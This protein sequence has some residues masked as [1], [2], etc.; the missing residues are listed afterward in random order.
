MEDSSGVDNPKASTS[1]GRRVFG[2]AAKT[3]APESRN[4]V[5]SDTFYA[6]SDSEDDMEAKENTADVGNNK[7]NDSQ[8]DVHLDSVL[9][10][11]NTEIVQ[12][13]VF[14]VIGLLW[15]LTK[16]KRQLWAIFLLS[17][18]VLCLF[19]HTGKNLMS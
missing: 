17:Q 8:K 2:A 16:K 11:E 14:K 5:K 9:P 3:H 6:N 10:H 13:S 12:D 15:V 1:S 18:K 4:M 7:S 19:I